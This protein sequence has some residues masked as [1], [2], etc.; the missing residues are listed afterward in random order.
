MEGCFVNGPSEAECCSPGWQLKKDE[1]AE[2]IRMASLDGGKQGEIWSRFVI[3]FSCRTK[4]DE[5]GEVEGEGEG[6]AT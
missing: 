2:A 4:L 5:A 3:H 6:E 1:E